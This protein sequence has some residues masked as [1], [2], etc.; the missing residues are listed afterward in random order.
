MPLVPL[1]PRDAPAASTNGNDGLTLTCA[2]ALFAME[3]KACSLCQ[4]L[5]RGGCFLC[6]GHPQP[7]DNKTGDPSLL[8]ST[9]QPCCQSSAWQ[10]VR[11]DVPHEAHLHCLPAMIP[12]S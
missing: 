9:K 3:G 2:L 11:R 6:G 4:P 1:L 10:P 7:L 8:S 5:V 12:I